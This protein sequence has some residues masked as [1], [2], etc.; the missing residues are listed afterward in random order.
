LL[1]VDAVSGD[2]EDKTK[3]IDGKACPGN[4]S[5]IQLTIGQNYRL[6]CNVS[7]GVAMSVW[8]FTIYNITHLLILVQF[9]WLLHITW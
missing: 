3:R 2:D 1:V 6:Q 4:G 9:Y 7:R 8:N 5:G